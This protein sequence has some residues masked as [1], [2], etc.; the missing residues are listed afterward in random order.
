MTRG[1]ALC[2]S[3]LEHGDSRVSDLLFYTPPT[4]ARALSHIPP[5]VGRLPPEIKFLVEARVDGRVAC[6]ER[7]ARAVGD[8]VDVRVGF[9]GQEGFTTG[10][11]AFRFEL[12]GL[13]EGGRETGRFVRRERDE[14]GGQWVVEGADERA[15]AAPL[16]SHTPAPLCWLTFLWASNSARIFSACVW[17]G[18]RERV[19]RRR[20]AG[21]ERERSPP[22]RRSISSLHFLTSVQNSS[23]LTAQDRRC[24]RDRR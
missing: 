19:R 13:C 4:H 15:T 12:V 6:V 20:A 21:E 5:S 8:L 11:E 24:L 10:E 16:S 7:P 3:F 23:R 14:Q 1:V 18:G 9:G 2:F 22:S 17:G